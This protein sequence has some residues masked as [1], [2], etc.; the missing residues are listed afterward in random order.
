MSR[1]ATTLVGALLLLVLVACLLAARADAVVTPVNGNEFGVQPETS[2]MTPAVGPLTYGGGPVVHASAP[3]ALFWDPSAG[4]YHAEWHELITDFIFGFA[5]DSGSLEN[6]FVDTEQYKDT[7]G[8]SAGDDAA[9]FG[10]YTD[11]DRYPTS[12]TCTETAPCLTDAQIRAELTSYIVANGLPTGLNPGGSRTPIY[13]VFTPPGTTVCLEG[14]G[15]RGHCSSQ[16]SANPLCS[17]HS[18]IPAGG[19]LPGA[20]LYAVEPWTAGNL[21]SVGAGSPVSGSD[22]QDGR[23]T[24]QEPNQV[25][26]GPNGEYNAG[27]ADLI[28]NDVA[29]EQLST[30]TDPLFT[31]WHDSGSNTDE[32]V[33][34]CRNYFLGGPL[35]KVPGTEVEEHTEA[36][37]TSNQLIDDTTYYLN[38]VF[39]QAG[40]YGPGGVCINHA[41]FR[42]EFAAQSPSGAGQALTFD[43]TESIVT[44][45]IASYRWDFGDGSSTVVNCE[46][47]TQTYGYTPA[48]C[49]S[50]S[51][52]GNPNPVA[53]VVHRYAYGGEY[54]V[55]LTE[56]DDGGNV[57]RVSHVIAVSGPPPPSPAHKEEG[58]SGSHTTSGGASTSAVT[59]AT[60]TG[61]APP[62]PVA[63][64]SVVSRTLSAAL[65][66]GIVV[67]YSVN[68]QVA[69]RFEVL[70][71]SSLARRVGLRGAPAT[72]LAKGTP[73]QTIIAKAI[74]VTTKGG[75]STYKIKF[76]KATA[77]RLRKLHKVSLM[78]RMVVHNAKSPTV[79]TVLDTVELR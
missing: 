49:T 48:Q 79:T 51:G 5:H 33:D 36:G 24:L 75:R 1:T 68:E 76:S 30:V 9:F 7:S 65:R 78:I 45:G 15:E 2:S 25:G 60:S 62:Q 26:W 72:G 55:T 35:E 63:T 39:N 59:P 16:S 46:G 67:R 56:T 4:G 18:Y 10:S 52:V 61:T 29:N 13:F 54:E 41:N 74:L 77:A 12:G 64:Q 19:S 38:D 40:V 8:A 53:S 73:P 42:P 27:L 70:L 44:L 22:C 69:G 50:S 14:S 58:A 28:N 66:E 31:A 57:A 20:V 71:A 6:V 17:Y 34:K 47:R 23:G 32:I 11:T 3:Y 21:G 37:K 43:T